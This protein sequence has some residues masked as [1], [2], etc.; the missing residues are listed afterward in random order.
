M[1]KYQTSLKYYYFLRILK[2]KLNLFEIFK[3]HK[4][5]DVIIQKINTL[6]QIYEIIIKIQKHFI[7]YQN[8]KKN[9]ILIKK[10]YIF[11]HEKFEI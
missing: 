7:N 10:K 6:K 11:Q 4:S 9:D 8:K 1:R 2:K 3:K 5:I